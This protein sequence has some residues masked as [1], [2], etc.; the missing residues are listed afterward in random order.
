MITINNYLSS[1]RAAAGGQWQ[2]ISFKTSP[3]ITGVEGEW[4]KSTREEGNY[5]RLVIMEH[6]GA[7]RSVPLLHSNAR[8]IMYRKLL[9]CRVWRIKWMAEDYNCFSPWKLPSDGQKKTKVGIDFAFTEWFTNGE[10]E[11]WKS[12]T[13]TVIKLSES[14]SWLHQ[15]LWT[16]PNLIISSFVNSHESSMFR[17]LLPLQ[18]D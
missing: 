5:F 17:H 9:L 15:N 3:F 10:D 4:R 14:K 1:P 12:V 8:M 6:L 16:L 7:L 2:E 13:L 11:R 18:Q